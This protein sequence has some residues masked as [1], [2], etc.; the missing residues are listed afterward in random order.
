[1]VA[2]VR[3]TNENIKYEA[4]PLRVLFLSGSNPYFFEV[5]R[6]RSS[7]VCLLA[8]RYPHIVEL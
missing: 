4:S 3:R 8:V 5:S 6:S 7:S 2:E 1:M